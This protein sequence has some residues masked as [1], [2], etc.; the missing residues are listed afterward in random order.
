VKVA[1]RR[2]RWFADVVTYTATGLVASALVGA[3]LGALG[4]VLVPGQLGWPGLLVAVAVAGISVTRESGWVAVPL[5]Q[6]RRQTRDTWARAFPSTVAAALWGLDLGLVFTTWL[7][8]SGVWVLAVVAVLVGEPVF[9]AS[10]F[11]LHWLG[12]A[13]S[14]WGVPLL[15]RDASATPWLLDAVSKQRRSLQRTHA[16]GV[17]WAVFVLVA[18]LAQQ[19]L[20]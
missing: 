19:S 14:V 10:L 11:A 9:G 18:W 7:T 8:F 6:V 17:A 13:F 2:R 12:R 15:M 16:L 1:G 4:R 3:A 5:P 20:G